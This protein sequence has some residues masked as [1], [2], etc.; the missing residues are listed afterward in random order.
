MHNFDQAGELITK[1][2]NTSIK[3]Y[4]RRISENHT[5]KLLHNYDNF[6]NRKISWNSIVKK[7]I[8]VTR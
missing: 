3:E 1:V 7:I 2:N 6:F 8:N 4:T 5:D